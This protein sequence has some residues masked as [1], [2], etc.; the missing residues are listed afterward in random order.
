MPLVSVIV[1]VYNAERHLRECLASIKSQSLT[2]FELLLVDDG[3]TDSTPAILEEFVAGEP[4]ARILTGPGRGTAGAARNLG[5]AEAR[6]DYLA[7]LDADDFFL[8]SMLEELHG[9]AVADDAD[10]VAAKFFVYND[11]TREVTQAEWM[12][13]VDELPRRRPFAGSDA[14]AGLFTAFNPAAWNKLFR[15]D[16]VRG[17]GLE[18]QEL[19]RTNDAYFT[20]MSLALAKKITYLDRHLVNYRVANSASLQATVHQDPLEFVQ[21]LEAMRATLQEK[22][23]WGWGEQALANLALNMCIGNLKRQ[24]APSSFLQLYDAL[25]GGLLERLGI[26][27]RPDGYILREDHKEWIERVMRQTP[28]EYLFLQFREAEEGAE[29]AGREARESLRSLMTMPIERPTSAPVPPPAQTRGAEADDAGGPDVSV[30]IPVY[31][32][33]VFLA[34]C[35]ESAQRQAGCSVEII[36]VDDGSQDGSGEV[37]DQYAARDPRIRVLHQ[38]NQGL[39]RARNAGLKAATGRY[40]VFLDSDDYW[41]GDGGLA[42]LVR[43]ADSRSLDVLLF[44]ATSVREPDVDDE[45]WEQYRTYYERQAYEGDYDGPGLLAAMNAAKEYRAS[46]C[47]F[48]AR[49]SHLLGTGLRFFPGIAHEDNLYTFSLLLDAPRAG[50]SRIALYGRRVRPGSIVSAGSRAAAVRGYFITWVEM[51]RLLRG[52]SFGDAEVTQQV[53]SVAQSIYSAARRN[54]SR[55]PEDVVAGL[56]GVD[57]DADA[58]ALYLLLKRGRVD[59][60]SKRRSARLLANAEAAASPPTLVRRAKRLAKRVLR[61]G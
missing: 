58:A 61:R 8:P 35:V 36:C 12:L 44:D 29:R 7:F 20:Y 42:E 37:L 13:K 25:R 52:R 46:A 32:T 39:S 54:A 59:E 6:G 23:A 49:R 40:V 47:L 34:E 27:D 1:P 24:T 53:A 55:L 10:V 4:R 50:H 57:G 43:A 15:A 9:R 45:L 11:V 38:A 51:V 26:L 21:A 28:A 19:R 3:S 31:N 18:F 5:M 2:D 56:A 16:F 17:H 41:Q 48:L 60:R 33:L 30:I 14:G 22:K